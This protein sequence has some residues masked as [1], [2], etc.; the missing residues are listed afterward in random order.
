M[1]FTEDTD[2]IFEKKRKREGLDASLKRFWRQKAPA[3]G[4]R[5]AD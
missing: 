3:K 4:K 1:W 2:E 5:A